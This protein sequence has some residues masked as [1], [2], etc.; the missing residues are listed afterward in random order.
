M[1]LNENDL[2]D[3]IIQIAFDV[4]I[5][6]GDD[7]AISKAKTYE[8]NTISGSIH[9]SGSW[10]GAVVLR[11]TYT[12][13]QKTTASMFGIEIEDI[14]E[15]EVSD[16]MGELVNMVGGNIKSILPEPTALSLPTVSQGIKSKLYIPDTELLTCVDFDSSGDYFSIFLLKKR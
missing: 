13:A 15:E 3:Q 4:W 10:N 5:S 12:L 8:G 2:K 9:I 11:S 14:S 1:I 6:L 7:I 16:A